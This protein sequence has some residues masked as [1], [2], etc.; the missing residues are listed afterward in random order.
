MGRRR[1]AWGV[2]CEGWRR[3]GV[4]VRVC[5]WGGGGYLACIDLQVEG[6]L[7]YAITTSLQ[8]A[9]HNL[10]V[11]LSSVCRNTAVQRVPLWVG[12]PPT[13][14]GIPRT[15]ENRI[16]TRSL[17]DAARCDRHAC[18]WGLEEELVGQT[19]GFE[20]G[21]VRGGVGVGGLAIMGAA[22]LATF[23]RGWHCRNG[24]N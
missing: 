19:H 10:A 23:A 1:G 7:E 4:V 6:T 12:G 21:R 20:L 8:H 18:S 3:V 2:A 16:A 14:H 5:V 24:S 17:F 9:G 11:H 15:H 13:K 22:A